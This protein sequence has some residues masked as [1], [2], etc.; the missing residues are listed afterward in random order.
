VAVGSFATGLIIDL[1]GWR[2][3]FIIPGI[4]TVAIGIAFALHANGAVQART[5]DESKPLFPA[6]RSDQ[7]AARIEKADFNHRSHQQ[8]IERPYGSPVVAAGS[9]TP[10]LCSATNGLSCTL[11]VDAPC[12]LV[13]SC[14][15]NATRRFGRNVRLA[16]S[17]R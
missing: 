2:A 1:A 3:A 12:R 15:T 5:A 14:K 7:Y 13:I 4:L 6:S 9:L 8:S 10:R 11:G 17:R 16:P